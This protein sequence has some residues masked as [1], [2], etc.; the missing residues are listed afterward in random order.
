MVGPPVAVAAAH[1]QVGDR[2]QAVR[3]APRPAAPGASRPRSR[4]L[5]QLG[6]ALGMRRVVAG[7]RVGRHLHQLLQE[8]HLL[9]EVGV[10]PGVEA[11][12]ADRSCGLLRRRSCSSSAGRP[13]TESCDVVVGAGL[14][15]VVADAGVEAAH[16]QHRL[17]HH[18]VQLHR[19][20]AGAAGHAEAAA[21]RATRPRAPSAAASRVRW[22]RRRR[23]CVSSS[24]KRRPRRSQIARQLGQHV[25]GAAHRARRRWSRAGRG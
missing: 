15:R 20:V 7:R 19:V 10:D 24:V 21:G 18:F 9:V 16:E 5:Q 8:A 6:G 23:A 11:G 13:R 12:V 4:S 3:P 22:A 17:R 1:D 14:E 2:L 25:G